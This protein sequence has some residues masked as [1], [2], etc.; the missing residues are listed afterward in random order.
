MPEIEI[1]SENGNVVFKPADL[2]AIPEDMVVWINRDSQA[3]L[4]QTAEGVDLFPSA[5]GPT[6]RSPTL[7]LREDDL[8]RNDEGEIIFPQIFAYKCGTHGEQGQ[9]TIVD[10]AAVGVRKQTVTNRVRARRRR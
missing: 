3:H 10:P 5:I 7:V 2:K 6:G 1:V 4:I 9:I 8:Q